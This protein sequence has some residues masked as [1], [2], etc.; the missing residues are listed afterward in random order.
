M[1][2]SE[3]FVQALVNTTNAESI[4]DR[5]QDSTQ[6]DMTCCAHSTAVLYA[7]QKHCTTQGPLWQLLLQV[8]SF[9]IVATSKAAP[10]ERADDWQWLKGILACV[11]CQCMPSPP[12][13]SPQ[14]KNGHHAKHR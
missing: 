13:Q 11:A 3:V 9:A 5:F 1:F 14:P 10:Q 8:K 6:L 7:N 12:R 4:K 2:G